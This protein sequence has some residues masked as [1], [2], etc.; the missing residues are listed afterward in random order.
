ML[1]ELDSKLGICISQDVEIPPEKEAV[2]RPVKPST[3]REKRLKRSA[4]PPKK[5]VKTLNK[6]L[7][8]LKWIPLFIINFLFCSFKFRSMGQSFIWI[9]SLRSPCP[10]SI[11]NDSP[12]FQ[13]VAAHLFL[14]LLIVSNLEC[15]VENSRLS[16]AIPL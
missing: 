9:C 8:N 16:R 2:R 6:E 3:L 5:V 7:K 10:F 1:D 11:H 4:S 14:Y 12:I 13:L 15:I